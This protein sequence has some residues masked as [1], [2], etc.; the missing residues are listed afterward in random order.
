MS[1]REKLL[2]VGA[3]QYASAGLK[4]FVGQLGTSSSI[5]AGGTRAIRDISEGYMPSSLRHI[6]SALQ[7]ANAMRVAV[8]RSHLVCSKQE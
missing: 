2:N 4:A 5:W 6:V 7:V 3:R 8:P 1:S